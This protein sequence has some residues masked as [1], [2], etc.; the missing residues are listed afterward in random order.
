MEQVDPEQLLSKDLPS[1]FVFDCDYTLWPLYVEYSGPFTPFGKH[2]A[3]DNNGS[4]AE[5]YPEAR[6]ILTRLQAKGVKIAAA[7]RTP[8]PSAAQSLLKALDIK[9]YMNFEQIY[10][11]SK[12]HHFKELAKDSGVE[13]KDMIFFDDEERNIRQVSKLGVTCVF[14]P[15]G[16]NWFRVSQGLVAYRATSK[17]SDT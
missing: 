17:K 11:G 1:L 7:S 2:K 13:Y 6:D 12:L 9:K 5:L 10:P 16:V 8:D 15:N 4:I 14:I 3:K